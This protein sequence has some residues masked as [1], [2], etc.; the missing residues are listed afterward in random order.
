[1]KVSTRQRIRYGAFTLASFAAGF[2]AT[3]VPLH[4]MAA[5]G[6]P[7]IGT[8]STTT[9]PTTN[10]TPVT[11]VN[12]SSIVFGSSANFP[13]VEILSYEE[14]IGV[15]PYTQI[16]Y[17]GADVTLKLTNTSKTV[18]DPAWLSVK[19]GN[20]LMKQNTYG[21][22]IPTLQ[23]GASTTVS[24]H[25]DAILPAAQ[26]QLPEDQQYSQWNAQ[27]RNVCGP[28]FSSVLDWRGPQAQTPMDPHRESLLVKEGWSDY[29][30]VPPSV[31]ICSGNQCVKVCDIEKKIRAQLD[32]KVTGYS[33]FVGQYPKFGSYGDARTSADAPETDFKSNTK[34]TV[35]SVSKLVTTIAAVRL[36]D[37]K[38]ISLDTAIGAYLPSDWNVQS[39]Y[40]KNITFAQLLGQ[41]S[42]IKD[43]G[44]VSMD[45]A[46]LKSF[47]SQ[48]V[49]TNANTMCQGSGVVNPAN[50]I[51]VNNQGWCYSNYN[52]A[53]MRVLLPK[54]AGFA[55]DANQA[56]RPQTLANQ[57]T[58][59]VQQNVF[60]L[61]GQNGVSCKPPVNSTNFAYAYKGP[62]DNSGGT[63]WGDVSLICGAAGWYLSVEDMAKVMLSLNAKDGKILA[64]SNGKDL[65]ETMRQRGLG[66]DVDTN[67]ELEKNGGWGAACDANGVC[68]NITTSV[69]MFGPVTGPRVLGV[70]F[71]NSNITGGGGAKGVLE[72]AYNNSLYIKP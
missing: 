37:Q 29:A 14:K 35:A 1:M 43:Y 4:A 61:V 6:T 62:S 56:T 54:V 67:T 15:V 34:I 27:Y 17:A 33:F 66:W 3:F 65:F 46:K 28:Q 31:P 64:A 26:S 36:L 7:V 25:L 57:Y 13:K 12:T 32:G 72:S 16:H 70:L 39:N 20:Q 21:V 11:T 48:A 50:P 10:T 69:A 55:E 60:N 68:D 23:P 63:N 59:L 58:Q 40:V 51:N 53:I 2:A 8:T 18:S 9:T 44:N 22:S 71:I 47:F 42:G 45:Y 49:N 5:S 52:F 19:D 30:K 38:G 41:R 24:V